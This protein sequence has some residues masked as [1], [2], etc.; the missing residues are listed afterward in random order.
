LAVGLAACGDDEEPTASNS[1]TPAAGAEPSG[2]VNVYS[3]LPLQGA[4]SPQTKAM[5]DGIKLALRQADS[6]VGG[7]TVKYESLDDSTAQAGKWEA[8]QVASNA[9]KAA[10]DK[11]A[12]AYI[13]EFNSGASAISIPLLNQ[14]GLAMISPAN[15]GVGLTKKEIGSTPGEPDKYYPT[16]K[17]TYARIVPRDKF[18]AADLVQQMKADGCTALAMA[19]DKEVY[20]A[21]LAILIESQAEEQGLKLTTNDGIQSD[22]ANFRAFATKIK[23]QGADCFVFAG[24]TANGAIQITKDVNAALP[25]AKLYGG[26]GVCESGFTNPDKKGIPASIGKLFKCTVGTL[27]LTSY[28][29]GQEF[30]AAFEKEYSVKSPDPY[31][32]YGYEAMQLVLD[33]IEAAGEAGTTREG[34]LAQLF[35]TKDR[36]SVLGQYSIDADG[37][38]TLTDYG[39]FKVGANGDPEYEATLKFKG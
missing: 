36:D 8:N 31:A 19:N 37:D 4:S 24:V 9:R 33:T 29:G 26:D 12:V 16:G 32:I 1:T 34:F 39:L 17:R 2:E 23:G 13:G 10:Q 7:V 28:P 3:S 6:K 14:V 18:Q 35:K 20:G 5:V 11:Q 38:T 27:D 25:E 15:T 21:G 30:L 22:A